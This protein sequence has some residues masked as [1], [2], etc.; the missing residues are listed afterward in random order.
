MEE[1]VGD[2]VIN[3]ASWISIYAQT[4]A[5]LWN[6]EEEEVRDE[7]WELLDAINA[8]KPTVE[9]QCRQVPVCLIWFTLRVLTATSDVGISPSLKAVVTLLAK[10]RPLWVRWLSFLPQG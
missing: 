1:V 7:Y 8:G 5:K 6:E 10:L 3:K 9:Q 2:R 4:S